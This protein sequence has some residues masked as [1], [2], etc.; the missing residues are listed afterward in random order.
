MDILFGLAIIAVAFWFY[1]ILPVQ[2]ATAR[3][4]SAVIW[5]LVS[6]LLSPIFAIVVLLLL[7][8]APVHEAQETQ[9]VSGLPKV[10]RQKVK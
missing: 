1:V 10:L 2:M 9:T 6:L 4:R 8:N 7:R 5:V 3:G